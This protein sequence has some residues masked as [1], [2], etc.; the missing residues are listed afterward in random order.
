[1]KSDIPKVLHPL[2]GKPLIK[3]VVDNLKHA[4]IDEITV[5]VGY[6]GE[7]VMDSLGEGVNYVWQRE[8]LGTG[9]AVLQAEPV[10]AGSDC[11][12]VVACGDVPLLSP[13]SFTSL[14]M[15]GQADNVKAV[16][17]T[18]VL[19]KPFGYGR[20]IRESGDVIARIVEEKDASE[21]EK[22]IQ[23]VNTG[24]YM[25]DCRLLFE[26]LHTVGCDNAQR[27]YYL[28]DVIRYMRQRGYLAKAL[29]LDDPM[30]GSGI[31]SP[32]DLARV[33]SYLGR[34]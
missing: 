5:V 18:M 34:M 13:E 7:S 11:S 27:E 15:A 33:E 24:T 20:I 23:E 1:M 9:H 21:A 19:E 6:R 3:H 26:A 30:R 2:Q 8:Q 14:A 28:P 16:V 22:A 12:V 32:E 29:V 31:N 25:F 10:L 4:G 17:L